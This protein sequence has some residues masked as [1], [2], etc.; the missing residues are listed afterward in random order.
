MRNRRPFSFDE[1]EVES[2]RRE[3]NEEI[4]EQNRRIDFNDIDRL[5]RDG[6]SEFRI[7]ADL[8]Q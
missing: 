6:D 4:G 1:I 2:H 7:P 8:Q 5:K 3:G